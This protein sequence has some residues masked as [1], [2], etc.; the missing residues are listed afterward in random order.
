MVQMIWSVPFID[1]LRS[2]SLAFDLTLS[3]LSGSVNTLFSDSLSVLEFIWKSLAAVRLAIPRQMLD[4]KILSV[5]T[6]GKRGDGTLTF[7]NQVVRLLTCRLVSHAGNCKSADSLAAYTAIN[8][9]SFLCCQQVRYRIRP[10]CD[11][12]SFLLLWP[13]WISIYSSTLLE[14]CVA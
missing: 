3:S 6:W 9:V 1:P 8:L 14:P 2:L 12:G 10:L 7:S 11:Q 4:K 5:G 13:R